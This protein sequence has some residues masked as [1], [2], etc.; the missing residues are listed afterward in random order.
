MC[1]LFGSLCTL[2]SNECWMLLQEKEL[3]F[4][5][6]TCCFFLIYSPTS[7]SW[8][9]KRSHFIWWVYY[10]QSALSLHRSYFIRIRNE[11]AKSLE[12]GSWQKC[13]LNI[14][15]SQ[16]K[17]DHKNCIAFRWTKSFIE[18]MR[19]GLEPTSLFQPSRLS[20]LVS[21]HHI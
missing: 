21:V 5:Q 8:E 20:V 17:K 9:L 11:D 10:L 15:S 12:C 18:I 14:K 4:R 16:A 3:K 2:K 13:F 19:F 6:I 1:N 7:L